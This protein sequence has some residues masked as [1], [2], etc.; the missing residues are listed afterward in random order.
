MNI[1][2]VSSDCSATSGAF[3]A[4][5]Y[6]AYELEKLGINTHIL[7]PTR[8]KAGED[9]LKEND[10]NYSYIRSYT[11]TVPIDHYNLSER[12]KH[13]IKLLI[14]QVAT[15]R[16]RNFIK[17]GKYDVVHINTSWHYVA[18][19]AIAHLQNRPHL[20]W[21][22]REFLEEDQNR[23]FGNKKKAIELMKSADSTIAISQTLADKYVDNLSNI[24]VILD[25]IQP[26]K[27]SLSN[28]SLFIGP[29]IR[30]AMVGGIGSQ[31][32]T[33]QAIEALHLLQNAFSQE[34]NISRNNI[35]L[36]LYGNCSVKA[37]DEIEHMLAAF[38]L[39]D[40]V[41]I[42]G[43]VL[44]VQQRLEQSDIFLM[45]SKSEAFGL[46]TVEAMMAGCLVIGANS[47]ATPE[48]IE[49]GVTGL[50]YQT[51]DPTDLSNNIKWAFDNPHEAERIA[52]AGQLYAL[53]N[54]TSERNAV[55]IMN[56]YKE[57]MD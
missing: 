57:L 42:H 15:I 23:R 22:I 53:A 14:N 12:F 33:Y 7:I 29:T 13:A 27:T 5:T 47:G 17:Q 50:L 2:L 10:I 49:N 35:V 41:I 21:H 18:A 32:G 11:W 51:D 30:L 25:G 9:L 44:N 24:R 28:R 56:L 48:I 43:F 38:H 34:S 26:P 52:K 19:K 6:L 1:L 46:V 39:R 40:K 54:F 8:N 31:K 37:K 55:E 36:D 45:C 4:M 3:R 20:I 16:M